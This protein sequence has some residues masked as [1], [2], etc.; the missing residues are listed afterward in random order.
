MHRRR[1]RST[2]IDHMMKWLA[3]SV[4]GILGAVSVVTQQRPVVTTITGRVAKAERVE[5]NDTRGKLVA[6]IQC[7]VILR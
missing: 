1:R 5:P 3:L 2:D 7:R 4:A 6:A